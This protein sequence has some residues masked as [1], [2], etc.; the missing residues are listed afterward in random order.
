MTLCIVLLIIL[1]GEKC[2]HRLSG[3]TKSMIYTVL[4]LL[5][6]YILKM[7]K[8]IDKSWYGKLEK[9]EVKYTTDSN[10]GFKPTIETLYT[11]E[12]VY[13]HVKVDNKIIK[14]KA[15]EKTVNSSNIS[16]CYREGDKVV[17]V[18]GTD[19]VQIINEKTEN[20][21]CVVCGLSNPGNLDECR[22]CH[23]TLKIGIE[24]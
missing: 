10:R 17:H 7:Y 11:K 12:T 16:L 1:F 14:R 4:V 21:I 5:P 2:F 20:V 18:Y 19:Y 13:F 8:L 24:E 6:L 23:H 22:S 3:T 9:I 15:Y